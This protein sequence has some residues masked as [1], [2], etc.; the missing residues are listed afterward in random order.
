MKIQEAVCLCGNK[1]YNLVYKN[2]Y[3][4]QVRDYKFSLYQCVNCSAVR[5][6][7]V[8]DIS[9]YTEGYTASTE[10]NS[11][12]RREKPWCKTLS[13]EV[14]EIIE[15][16]PS[17]KGLPVLDVGC[18]G[19]EL[20]E[21][22][23]KDG[24]NAEGC[25]VDPI[26]VEYGKSKGLNLFI[27]DLASHKLEKKYSVVTLNHTLEHIIP[28]Q[29]FMQNIYDSIVKDGVLLIH[30]PNY[31]SWISRIMKHK[32]GFLAPHEHVWQFTPETLKN[33]I[34]NSSDHKMEVIKI[35][36][37]TSL[38]QPGDGVKGFIKKII[39]K[40]S[41]LFDQADEIIATFRKKD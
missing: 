28:A 24:L 29:V 8:P 16:H 39:I 25:D 12:M 37:K 23:K 11:Y 38:E 27:K 3:N 32:W 30:V 1:N 14:V 2:T 34:L 4:R 21:C 6:D 10:S 9:L 40:F 26:A 36:C 41:E 31:N 5:V 22:M 18:N 20:V 7:P 15:D 13:K 17:L 33:F 19:G 35:E